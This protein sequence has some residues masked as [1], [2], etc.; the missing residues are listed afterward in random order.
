MNVTCQAVSFFNSL[1]ASGSVCVSDGQIAIDEL[2][3]LQFRQMEFAMR[4]CSCIN[5]LTAMMQLGISPAERII[6]HRN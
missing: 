6:R 4:K 3:P 5:C 2:T 1:V